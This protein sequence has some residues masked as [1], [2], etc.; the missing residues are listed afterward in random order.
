MYQEFSKAFGAVQ[1]E[2]VRQDRIVGQGTASSTI[3]R[4]A[5]CAHSSG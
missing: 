4:Q 5:H 2:A 1:M 3:A